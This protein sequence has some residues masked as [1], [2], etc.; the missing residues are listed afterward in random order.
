M[1]SY[2]IKAC[3]FF[4]DSCPDDKDESKKAEVFPLLFLILR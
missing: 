4:A 1:Y 2:E 3:N